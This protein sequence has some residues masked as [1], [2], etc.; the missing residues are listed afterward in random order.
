[1]PD[2][3]LSGLVTWILWLASSV[4][5]RDVDVSCVWRIGEAWP[6][7]GMVELTEDPW[8]KG[9]VDWRGIDI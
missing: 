7:L 3:V 2:S 5:R 4:A 9:G 6:G 1:M 8:L